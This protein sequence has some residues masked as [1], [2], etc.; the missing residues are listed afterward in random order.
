MSAAAETP[1]FGQGMN[2]LNF[3]GRPLLPLIRQSEA[4]ECGLACLAMVAGYHGHRTTLS[5]MRQR[6]PISLRGATLAQLM[7]MAEAMALDARPL[8]AELDEL[9]QLRTPAIL[10]WDLSHFV[11]LEGTRR[12]LQGWRY[13]I[14]DPARGVLHLTADEVSKHWTGVALE[15]APTRAFAKA[16]IKVRLRL[17]QLGFNLVGLKS[18]LIQA[19]ALSLL[20]ELFAFLAPFYLQ[21]A[22]DKAVPAFDTQFLAALALGF[23]GLA[24]VGLVTRG[25]RELM[26]LKL[27]SAVGFSM[28]ADLFRHLLKLPIGFFERRHT[29]D[30]LSRFESTEPITGL[31][32]HGLVSSMIDALMALATLAMMYVYSPLLA[33]ITIAALALFAALRIATFR[34]LQRITVDAIAAKAEESSTMIETVRGMATIK[35]FGRERDRLRLWQN[36]RADSI[37]ADIRLGR[38]TIAFSVASEGLTRLEQVLFVYLAVSMV[39]AGGFTVGMIF[40]FQ[41]YK[42]QF[43]DAGLRFVDM[44][45]RLKLLDS[46]VDR[47]ADIALE[48]PEPARGPVAR[49]GRPPLRGR[50]ELQGVRFAYGRDDPEVLR[51]IDLTIEPGDSI[52]ITGPSGGG[53][54]TLVKLL[55]GF[56]PPS[57][58]QI[59]IDGEPLAQLGADTFRR[60]VGAV[61]QDDVLYAGSIAD[62]IAFFDPEIDLDLVFHCARLACVHDDIAALPMGYDS[63]VGDMGSVLS[64]GQKQRLFLARALYHRPRI[65]LLDEGTA[66]LDAECEAA[67]NANLAG[68]LLTRIMVAHRP[69]TIAT[70]RRVVWLENGRL[71]EL[72]AVTTRIGASA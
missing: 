36:K 7:A 69:K 48:A 29:G 59:L 34:H 4:A 37:N 32:S 41:A 39:I 38:M 23:A 28:V 13:V 17:S 44:A 22:V 16:D 3:T 33:S 26:L 58:G 21:L 8:R 51:G 64:G 43:L 60:H 40:A 5:H 15:L 46:H 42:S 65:L 52:A 56:Y 25:L 31:L 62:N 71:D 10:H 61:R 2:L 66:N 14:H 72:R 30:V 24:L 6:F 12:T 9:P 1:P 18:V 57:A 35:L 45:Y 19:V 70:A 20:L 68:L 11:V 67:V 50:I 49:T 55:L 54:S 27:S 53:K 47:I 63:L